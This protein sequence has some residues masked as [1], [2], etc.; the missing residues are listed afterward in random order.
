MKKALI[1]ALI[2]VMALLAVGC[3]KEHVHELTKVEGYAA[4]CTATGVADYWVCSGCNKLFKNANAT[5]EYV[6]D[7]TLP[8]QLT[9]A[10]V[11]HKYV[12]DKD[13]T[14]PNKCK[15]CDATVPAEYEKHETNTDDGDC[16]TKVTC[17]HRDY[18]FVEAKTHTGGTADCTNKANCENCGKAYGS[19][20]ADAHDF[21]DAIYIW[22]DDF[23]TCTAAGACK[24]CGDAVYEVVATTYLSGKIYADFAAPALP[25]QSKVINNHAGRTMD[26]ISVAV[27]YMIRNGETSNAVLFPDGNGGVDQATLATWLLSNR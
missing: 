26:E 12:D 2:I 6:K 15:T 9:L 19:L 21:S 8:Q 25:S 17:Q 7:N 24:R 3:S 22:A 4:T 10:I 11:D 1:F 14:T 13:C 5:E 23:S 18:V 27:A 20:V 16:T